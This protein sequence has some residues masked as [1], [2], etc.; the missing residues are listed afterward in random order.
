LR[1]YPELEAH[2]A[3]CEAQIVDVAKNGLNTAALRGEAW[4]IRLIL[5]TKG[6]YRVQ[7]DTRVS[8]D[9]DAPLVVRLKIEGDDYGDDE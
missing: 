6:G 7:N 4:A 5:T 2:R 1:K 3:D 8:G 9:K